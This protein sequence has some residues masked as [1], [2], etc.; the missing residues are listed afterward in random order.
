MEAVAAQD[1]AFARPST[2]YVQSVDRAVDLLQAVAAGGPGGTTVVSLAQSCGLNRATAW[3]LLT[4]LEARGMVARDRTSGKFAIGPAVPVLA[5]GGGS[6]S[7]VERAQPILER[8]SLETGEIACLGLVEGEAVEYVAEVIPAIVCEQ[9]WLGE[10]VVLHASSMGKAFLATL[11]EDRVDSLLGGAQAAY[12]PATI[13]DPDELTLELRR[14]RSQGYAVCAGELQPGSWGVAAPVHG[15]DGA[16]VAVLCLWG[17][18]H[19]GD[20]AR[21]AALGRLARRAAREITA[22]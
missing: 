19:R 8:L 11:D 6:A 18:G 14:I 15:D 22:S 13:T 3:R 16:T 7:L 1:A 20:E 17:P 9:S 10:H 12:T 21:L 5:A 4:T 2:T